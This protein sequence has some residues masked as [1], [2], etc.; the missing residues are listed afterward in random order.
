M[1]R[2][3]M[4]DLL[5]NLGQDRPQIHASVSGRIQPSFG[6]TDSDAAACCIVIL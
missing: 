6:A 4:G 5:A 1:Q 2:A 3:D